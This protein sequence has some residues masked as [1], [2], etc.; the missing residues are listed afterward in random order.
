MYKKATE[1]I[2]EGENCEGCPYKQECAQKVVN[3]RTIHMNVELMSIHNEV[4]DYLISV[5]RALLSV[6]R[7]IQVEGTYG[8]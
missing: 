6:N 5:H 2:Y 7:S 8:V 1:D 3:N 4:I